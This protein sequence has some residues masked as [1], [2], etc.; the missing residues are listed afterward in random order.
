MGKA[1]AIELAR[2][3]GKVYLACRNEER[4]LA[5]LKDI[6]EM[7]GSENVILLLLD[8]ASLESIREFSKKFH[9]VENRLD[10]LIN[11][12]G[13]L[14]GLART[15]D[16]FEL[17]MGTNH[18]GHFL[19]TNL[20]L[21]L[22]KAAAPS[23]IV[24]VSSA[25]HSI[26]RIN[27][28]DFNSEKSFAGSWKAYGNSK[29]ANI[30]FARQLSKMLEGT[31]VTVNSLCPGAVNTEAT[32]NLNPILKFFMAPIYKIFCK[33]PE[34]GCQTIVMLAVEPQLENVSGK[35]FTD[36]REKEP[37]HEAKNDETASWLWEHS[38]KITGLDQ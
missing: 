21:D 16:E 7:S 25:L 37:S 19:L 23:R 11:N 27:R 31:G 24:V 4:G 20:L 36:C 1:T 33:T 2:R 5:A 9:E 17:N 32:R 38:L 13:L 34:V 29:L 12:A 18:I 15:K 35:Y 3:G 28:D 26:G 14:H 6:K 30:L 22:I 8:L 10:I